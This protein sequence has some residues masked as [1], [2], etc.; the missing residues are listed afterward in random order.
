MTKLKFTLAALA[1][2]SLIGTA[3]A[4]LPLPMA[5]S[6]E[7][8]GLSSAQF[9]KIEA[10]TKAHIDDGLM[11][12]AVMLVARRGKVAWVSVQGKRDAAAPDAM[13]QDSIFRIYS[14]TK[15]IVS[16]TLMQLVEEGRL[17]ISDPVSKYL[18]EIGKMKVGT[19]AAG[20]DGRPV[21]HLSDQTRPMTVQDLLRHTSGLTYGSR[22]ASQINASYVEAGI[23]DRSVTAEE[24]VT[25]LSKLALKFNPGDR[26]EYSVAVDVQGRLIEVITG[27]KLSEAVAER[28]LQPL[29]MKDTGFQVPADKVARAAQPGPR[30]SG[31]PMTPRFKVDDGA[32][33]ESGGG[34]MMSTLEDYLRFT[35]A[36]ANGGVFQGKR[37]I[38]S[39]TLEF[40]TA[41]H[42][43]NRPG[44]PPGL[45]FGLGFEVRQRTGDSALPGSVGE[46]GWAGNAGTLFWIDPKEQLIAIYMVQVS[47]PDRIALRNQFRTMVQAALID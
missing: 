30:P 34:G 4:Q 17:Q 27:K 42:T 21:L 7:E 31:Q 3:H 5:A 28:I 41:D 20:P 19:E 13:K 37:I 18:P 22:G 11:P 32:K 15:P 2:A 9:K 47:D 24:M 8:V 46:Y 23:G 35:S 39:K 29:G 44:R 16:V 45:G 6:P 40:M 43:L 26:W 33:Y 25:R 36:L 12:G 14:M 1:L 10:V 38:G